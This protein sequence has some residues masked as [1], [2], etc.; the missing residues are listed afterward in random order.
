M[1]KVKNSEINVSEVVGYPV[2]ISSESKSVESMIQG[3]QEPKMVVSCKSCGQEFDSTFSVNDFAALSKEQHEAGTLHLCPFC[4][5][6]SIYEMKDY[7]E[8][9]SKPS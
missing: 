8:R 6:L 5:N 2:K 4:G 3:D 9:Q 1:K 7:H